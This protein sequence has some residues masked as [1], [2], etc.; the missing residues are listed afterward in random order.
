MWMK[1]CNIDNINIDNN[2]EMKG[3]YDF[4]LKMLYIDLNHAPIFFF[5]HCHEYL[6]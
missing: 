2:I 5:Y 3:H 4:V 1:K 6:L